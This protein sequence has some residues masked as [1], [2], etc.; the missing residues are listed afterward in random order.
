MNLRPVL[1][2][3]DKLKEWVMLDIYLV[4]IG[5]ACIKV[6]EYAFIQP[7]PGLIAFIALVI[8]S[9]L[10]MIHLNIEQLWERFYPQRPPRAFNAQLRVCLGCH[11]TGCAGRAR[12]LPS[13]PRAAVTIA[14]SK[15][16]KNPGQR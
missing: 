16:Y 6:R 11:F 13:M 1:L 8:L 12:P 9:L 14:V 10:T 3:L 4:G 7:G 2:M 15:A 5:V